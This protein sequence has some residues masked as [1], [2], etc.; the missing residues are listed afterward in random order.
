MSIPFETEPSREHLL[1]ENA[2]LRTALSLLVKR[3]GGEVILEARDFLIAPRTAI[4][5]FFLTA[6]GNY[7]ITV[8]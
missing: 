2:M 5:S 8:S 3:A 4:L 6:E 1:S 7:R